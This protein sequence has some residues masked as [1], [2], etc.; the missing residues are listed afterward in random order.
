[1]GLG[2]VYCVHM[3]NTN[4]RSA[5]TSALQRAWFEQYQ[6]ARALRASKETSK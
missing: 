2:V 4:P 1:M 6:I 3:E 5:S